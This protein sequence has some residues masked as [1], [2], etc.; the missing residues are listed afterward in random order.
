MRARMI[1]VF[2]CAAAAAVPLTL[3]AFSTGPPIKRTGAPVDGGVTCTACHTSFTLNDASGGSVFIQAV[4]YTPG[5]KQTITVRGNHP[6]PI[7]FG[8]QLTAPLPSDETK[9]ARTF[10]QSHNLQGPRC[11]T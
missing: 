5:V 6:T 10:S 7:P 1:R 3:F 2:K 4:P 8:F 9:E 11:P